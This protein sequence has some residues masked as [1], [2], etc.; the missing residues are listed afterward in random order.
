MLNI[1]VGAGLSHLV[2]TAPNLKD[3]HDSLDRITR[4]IKKEN[5]PVPNPESYF[6][7]I[8]LGSDEAIFL[9]PPTTHKIVE[10]GEI[11]NHCVGNYTESVLDNSIEI[12]TLI[13]DDY[14]LVCIEIKNRYVRQ[15][16]LSHN[17]P[18]KEEAKL[19]KVVVEW[20]NK[21]KLT[22]STTDLKV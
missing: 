12:V 1:I 13:V 7:R 18:V 14:P 15:A 9:K 22:I 17:R 20:A 16:K 6:F 10:V 11:M 19:N 21:F 5:F 3:F 4:K 2:T 8:T